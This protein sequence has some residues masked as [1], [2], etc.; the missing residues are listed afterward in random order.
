MCCSGCFLSSRE[1]LRK[2]RE[3]EQSLISDFF[4]EAMASLNKLKANDAPNT[5]AMYLI[6]YVEGYRGNPAGQWMLG[7]RSALM[8]LDLNLNLRLA[9]HSPT[10][11][12]NQ[13]SEDEKTARS[14]AFWGCFHVMQ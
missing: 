1:D 5:A 13:A 7:G 10:S 4:D 6:S 8:A 3:D 2:D 12:S 9:P 11:G 14:H